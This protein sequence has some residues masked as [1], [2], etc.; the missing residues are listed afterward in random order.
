MQQSLYNA[1]QEVAKQFPAGALRDK[2]VQ[3]AKNFR[4]PYFDWASQPPQGSTAFPTALS[5][6]NITIVDVDGKTKSTANPL[7]RFT[8]HPVN[9][10]PGDFSQQVCHPSSHIRPSSL[11]KL[12]RHL[13]EPVPNHSPLSEPR[14]RPVAGL[15]H[16]AH[17]VQR[18]SLAAQQHWAATT[19][20]HQL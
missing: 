9:P 17:P 1:V 6:P 13:V 15:A 3:A 12:T 18:A 11:R 19:L 4:A 2:Y 5:S 20:I 16:R 14:D 7:H 10:S 8:F